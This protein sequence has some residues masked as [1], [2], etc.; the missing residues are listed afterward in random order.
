M[1]KNINESRKDIKSTAAVLDQ[2]LL[3][4]VLINTPERKQKTVN[5]ANQINL[6][7]NKRICLWYRHYR[8][9]HI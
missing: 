2:T 9:L 7:P 6:T 3:I 5:M 8:I 1:N 4:K